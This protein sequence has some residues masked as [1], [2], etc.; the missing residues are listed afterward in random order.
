[1]TTAIE[2]A[3]ISNEHE[4]AILDAFYV[5]LDDI[6]NQCKLA[7]EQHDYMF[8]DALLLSESINDDVRETLISICKKMDY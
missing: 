2:Y 4:N 8:V 3:M 5:P 6:E 1:M 7:L